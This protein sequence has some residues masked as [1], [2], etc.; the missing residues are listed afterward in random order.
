MDYAQSRFSA[1]TG[2]CIQRPNW[3]QNF[4]FERPESHIDAAIIHSIKSIPESA[5]KAIS[6]AASG[7]MVKFE[8]HLCLFRKSEKGNTYIIENSWRPSAEDEAATDW[9]IFNP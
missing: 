3:G 1:R 9:V 2:H 4:V 6:E 5:R 8:S 7:D